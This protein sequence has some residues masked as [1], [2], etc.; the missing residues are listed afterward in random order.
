MSGNKVTRPGDLGVPFRLPILILGFIS[1][2][3]GMGAGLLR[4]GWPVPFPP[5]ELALLH[6]PLMLSGFLGTV[7]GL[8]RAVALG[9]RW[10]YA[11]PLL[12]GLGGFSILL[13]F[14]QAVGATAIAC[15]SAALLTASVLIVQRQ[16]EL[17]TVTMTLGAASW[18]AGNLLWLSGLPVAAVAALWINFLVLTIAG[19]RLELSRFLPPSPIAKRVFATILAVLLASSVMILMSRG[20]YLYGLGLLAL[21]IWLL[22]QDIARRTVKE[23]D[24]TRFIAVCLLSGYV[25][26]AL[27]SLALLAAGGLTGAAYDA[28]LHAI[29]IGFVFSMVFGHA[30]IIFP[31][32]VRVKMPYHWTFYLPLLALHT[33]LIVRLCGDWLDLPHLRNMGG[34]LNAAA[35]ALFI[36]STIASVIRGFRAAKN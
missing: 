9:R 35:L 20:T 5:A 33:S 27:G 34:L 26:L 6:G 8:E 7:I 24:L 2:A 32:V 23:S 4:L 14:P 18:L 15:G 17:F 16:R 19:E 1:L 13:G 11:G 12:T 3:T 22:R 30:P 25:W 28:V 36:L 21:A 10:A 31:S 29:L